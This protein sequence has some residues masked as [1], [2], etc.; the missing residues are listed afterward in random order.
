MHYNIIIVNAIIIIATL[1]FQVLMS[2]TISYY[3]E[4]DSLWALNCTNLIITKV[5]WLGFRTY[6]QP[7]QTYMT[8]KTQPLYNA[9]IIVWHDLAYIVIFFSMRVNAYL[10]LYAF[11]VCTTV[12]LWWVHGATREVCVYVCSLDFLHNSKFYCSH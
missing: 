5:T 1:F 3:E 11:A 9:W 2:Q 8:W 4:M 7:H 10:Y 12:M 6:T